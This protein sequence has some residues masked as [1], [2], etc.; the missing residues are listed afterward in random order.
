VERLVDILGTRI[1]GKFSR[2]YACESLGKLADPKA[3]PAIWDAAID[4]DPNL[5]STAV[6]AL[7]A[8]GSPE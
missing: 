4:A 1:R 7:G 6:S 5:R 8:F 2:I 3:L